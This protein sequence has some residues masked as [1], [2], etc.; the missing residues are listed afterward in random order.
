LQT[1]PSCVPADVPDMKIKRGQIR[2]GLL[3][4]TKRSTQSSSTS[5]L[6]APKSRG[7]GVN[8]PKI[9]TR[10]GYGRTELF[11]MGAR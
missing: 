4:T 9:L 3:S 7:V 5:R 6:S 10:T 2:V 11:G 1:G 8:E